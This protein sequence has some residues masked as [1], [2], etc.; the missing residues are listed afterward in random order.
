MSPGRLPLNE[1][2]KKMITA[3][4]EMAEPQ[5][6]EMFEN[7]NFSTVPLTELIDKSFPGEWGGGMIIKAKEQRL[8]EQPVSQI[9]I[10]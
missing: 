3:I 6:I 5:F 4:D 9:V 2:Y 7:H 1:A 10:N 8:S